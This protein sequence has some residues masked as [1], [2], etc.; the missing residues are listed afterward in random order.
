MNYLKVVVLFTGFSVV[1]VVDVV[2]DVGGIVDGLSVDI[3]GV[4]Y[5]LC[6]GLIVDV[7]LGSLCTLFFLTRTNLGA[8]KMSEKDRGCGV[9]GRNCLFSAFLNNCSFD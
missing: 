1:V 9:L 2:E 3:F 5:I 6:G 4:V 7:M 8:V